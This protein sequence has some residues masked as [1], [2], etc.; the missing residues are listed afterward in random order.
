MLRYAMSLPVAVT[1]SGIDSPDVLRQNLRV[2]HG[3]KPMTAGR[4]GRA[5]QALCRDRRRR[6]LRAV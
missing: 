2:A 1:I 5:A 6:T 4:N 3:F